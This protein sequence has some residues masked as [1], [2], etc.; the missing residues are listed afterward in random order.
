MG[1]LLGTTAVRMWTIRLSEWLYEKEH[2]KLSDKSEEGRRAFSMVNATGDHEGVL[3]RHEFLCYILLKHSILEKSDIDTIHRRY[4][5]MIA[6]NK[7]RH[8]QR[9]RVSTES[10]DFA[11]DSSVE[12]ATW[13][14]IREM[15]Q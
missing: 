10:V 5:M 15:E 7:V 13:D 8:S 12:G 1:M 4:D 3:S 9:R 11:S 14:M 6:E 2:Q